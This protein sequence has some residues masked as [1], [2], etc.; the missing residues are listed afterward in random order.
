[1][2]PPPSNPEAIGSGAPLGSV[3]GAAFPGADEAGKAPDERV[4]EEGSGPAKAERSVVAARGLRA[5]T[6]TAPQRG[7]GWVVVPATAKVAPQ[8]R[9]ASCIGIVPPG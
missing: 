5:T 1:M 3:P 6:S 9:Q 4:L 2:R 8:R 7:Q